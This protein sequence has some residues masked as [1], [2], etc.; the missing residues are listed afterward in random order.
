MPLPLKREKPKRPKNPKRDKLLVLSAMYL[1]VG[2]G[3]PGRR[4]VRTRHN[5][6]FW[7]ADY[8]AKRYR[9][10][11]WRSRFDGKYGKGTIAG[12]EVAIFKP[13]LFMNRSGY[14]V[15][16]AV[17]KLGVDVNNILVI[18][19]DISLPIGKIRLRAKGSDGGHK[20]LRSII[21]E[22]GTSDFPRL[23]IGV[24]PVPEF[25]DAAYYV[26]TETDDDDYRILMEEIETIHSGIEVF[27]LGNIEAAMSQ[28]NR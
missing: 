28:L 18:A 24:G 2:L 23:K 13:R 17:K 14:S 16:D 22:L 11:M 3:N 15:Y 26:L 9:I 20:G 27:L 25:T 1:I 6:G 7:A 4:Y 21:E 8:L 5:V 12:Q 10:R 19:D